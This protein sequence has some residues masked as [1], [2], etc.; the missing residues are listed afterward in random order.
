MPDAAP[1]PESEGILP[2]LG[3]GSGDG[4]QRA[5]D[6]TIDQDSNRRDLFLTNSVEITVEIALQVSPVAPGEMIPMV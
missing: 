1:P 6:R 5:V 4:L 2:C 3:A